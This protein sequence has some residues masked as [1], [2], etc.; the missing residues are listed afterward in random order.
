MFEP[1]RISEYRS[2]VSY[3]IAVTQEVIRISFLS[4]PDGEFKEEYSV[5]SILLFDSNDG[6]VHDT[7]KTIN[8]TLFIE[9]GEIWFDGHNVCS[10]ARDMKM[11]YIEDD[12]D[13]PAG[14]YVIEASKYRDHAKLILIGGGKRQEIITALPDSSRAVYIAITGEHCIITDTETEKTGEKV[15]DGDIERIADEISYIER[16]ESDLPN[17]QIDGY[18]TASTESV[19]VKDD[20]RIIFHTMSLPTANLVGHCPFIIL[21]YSDDGK[22]NGENYREF[23]LIRLDGEAQPSVEMIRSASQTGSARTEVRAKAHD[24]LC[25]PAQDEGSGNKLAVEKSDEFRGWDAWKEYNKKG[26]E[27][28]AAILRSRKRITV[29]TEN[30]GISIKNITTITDGT[31]DV[32]LALSGDQ[33]ALTDIRVTGM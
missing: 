28:E 25:K 30:A 22:V 20:M 8:D 15:G 6:C 32:Y 4:S 29:I 26:F 2:K 14:R 1:L 17:V 9:Y 11:T 5:P 27:C 33:C 31:K 19:P 23:A 13:T 24:L 3:G 21:F 18:R 16:M 10:G 12:P 7:L